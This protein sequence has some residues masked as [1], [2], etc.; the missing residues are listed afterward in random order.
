MLVRVRWGEDLSQ[1][2][3]LVAFDPEDD[4]SRQ[5]AGGERYQKTDH[6]AD[7]RDRV[8]GLDL[9]EVIGNGIL[10]ASVVCASVPAGTRSSSDNTFEL[11][12]TSAT[13]SDSLL[14]ACPGCES[15]RTKWSY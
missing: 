14:E 9:G 8:E 6:L 13:G 1:Q 5:G 11:A 12:D 3:S 10:I 15:R 7:P 2:G 4:R